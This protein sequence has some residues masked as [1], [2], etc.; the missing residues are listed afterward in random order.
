MSWSSFDDK[1]IARPDPDDVKGDLNMEQYFEKIVLLQKGDCINLF[2][3]VFNGTY[4]Y[5]LK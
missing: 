5:L 3:F 1:D 4:L 2:V